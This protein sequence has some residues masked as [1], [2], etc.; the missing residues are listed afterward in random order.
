MT[1]NKRIER[2][3]S[4]LDE[5]WKEQVEPYDNSFSA[6]KK[7]IKKEIKSFK[8]NMIYRK[9]P[10]DKQERRWEEAIW[11][12]KLLLIYFAFEGI[13]YKLTGR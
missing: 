12:G 1:K 8:E 3:I 2:K 11:W 6:L 7:I 10:T 13:V 9:R 4:K 5:K